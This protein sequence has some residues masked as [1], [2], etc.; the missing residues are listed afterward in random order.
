VIV[1]PRDVRLEDHVAPCRPAARHP[2]RPWPTGW[3]I[4]TGMLIVGAIM[5]GMLLAWLSVNTSSLP[6]FVTSDPGAW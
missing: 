3:W 1:F 4:V 5:V 6:T 2:E